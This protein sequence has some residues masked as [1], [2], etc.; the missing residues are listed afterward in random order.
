MSDKYIVKFTL[1]KKQVNQILNIASKKELEEY[2]RYV[3]GKCV[4][5]IFTENNKESPFHFEEVGD[6]V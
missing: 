2:I 1:T 6:K 5:Y 4:D 3:G